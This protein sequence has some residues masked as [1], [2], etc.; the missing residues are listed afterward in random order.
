MGL[1]KFN[2]FFARHGHNIK[3][4]YCIESVS[5]TFANDASQPISVYRTFDLV[6]TDRDAQSWIITLIWPKQGNYTFAYGLMRLIENRLEIVFASQ[7]VG[8]GKTA[9]LNH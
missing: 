6:L 5:K 3:A 7:P 9:A 4:R 1:F 8:A 2:P